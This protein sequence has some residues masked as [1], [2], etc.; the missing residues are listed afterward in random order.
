MGTFHFGSISWPEHEIEEPPSRAAG[1][2]SHSAAPGQGSAAV[3]ASRRAD[4]SR[5]DRASRWVSCPEPSLRSGGAALS[6]TLGAIRRLPAASAYARH[7]AGAW[8]LAAGGEGPSGQRASIDRALGILAMGTAPGRLGVAGGRRGR[9][10][11]RAASRAGEGPAA[12]GAVRTGPR[13]GPGQQ[14]EQGDNENPHAGSIGRGS[15]MH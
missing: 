5:D 7:G 15:T 9:A 13:G 6:V 14:Q 12:E 8:A 4:S 10:A 1:P 11:I 2:S 3:H